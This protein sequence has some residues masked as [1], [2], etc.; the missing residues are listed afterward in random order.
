MKVLHSELFAQN[1]GFLKYIQKQRGTKFARIC[2]SGNSFLNFYL[3]GSYFWKP[4]INFI[5]ES[6]KQRVIKTV[7]NT[8]PILAIYRDFFDD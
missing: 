7:I 6:I 2:N 4:F 8:F 1:S 5:Y 3:G